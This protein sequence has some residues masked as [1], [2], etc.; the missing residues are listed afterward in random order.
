M[1]LVLL[2]Y[3]IIVYS[4]LTRT[5][6]FYTRCGVHLHYHLQSCYKDWESRWSDG[7]HKSYISKNNSTTKW[8]ACSALE[9]VL[10]H[11]TWFR[12]FDNACYYYCFFKN[13]LSFLFS[14]INLY[15]L[16]E[17]P[18]CQ[19]YVYMKALNLAVDGKVT[20]YIIPSFKKI[21]SF[22]KDWKIGIPEQQE[23]F[24]TISNILK[25]NKRYSRKCLHFDFNLIFSLFTCRG[26]RSIFSVSIYH[27]DS[28]LGPQST[29][30]N[31]ENNN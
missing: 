22:L 28:P 14:L 5:V 6:I 24:L 26:S 12:N 16:L 19:F 7:D 18:Y 10:L 23:L 2:Y 3:T 11:P 31:T 25:E 21:D 15:N 20:E 29:I 9:D 17:T 30:H 1:C 4:M 27:D 13:V 8:K